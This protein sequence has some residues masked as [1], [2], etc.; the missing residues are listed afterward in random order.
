[1]WTWKKTESK[2]AGKENIL[3]SFPAT[4]KQDVEKV[5][6]ILS[7]DK[8]YLFSPDFQTINLDKEILNIPCRIYFDEP[9]STK[10]MSL[11]EQ[12]RTI[13]NCILLRHHDGYLRQRRLEL[14]IDK[15]EYFVV[16]FVFQLLGEY[17]IEILFFWTSI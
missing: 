6:D 12:Q 9:S 5:V 1:M 17:V 15:T 16:P 11:T 10:E 8:N 7:F 13:L 3:N 14:L 4:L 2:S